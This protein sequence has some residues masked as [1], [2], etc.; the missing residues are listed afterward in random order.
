MPFFK[1]FWIIIM[2]VAVLQPL[3]A[4]VLTILSVSLV[5]GKVE[6]KS[7]SLIHSNHLPFNDASF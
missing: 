2:Q 3:L 1:H 7:Q 4:E 6:G 5:M